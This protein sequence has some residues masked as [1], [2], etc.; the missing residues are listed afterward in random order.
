MSAVEVYD[1]GRKFGTHVLSRMN[2]YKS[3]NNV[4]DTL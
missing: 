4:H 1:L 3:T 2:S